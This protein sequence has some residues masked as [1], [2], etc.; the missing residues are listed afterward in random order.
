MHVTVEATGAEELCG[1]PTGGRQTVAED[2][3]DSLVGSIAFTI[4]THEEHLVS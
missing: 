2:G 1:T 4:V 3:E